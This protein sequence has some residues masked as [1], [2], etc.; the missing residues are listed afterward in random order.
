MLLS[1]LPAEAVIDILVTMVT[2][3][4]ASPQGAPFMDRLAGI[5]NE[6]LDLYHGRQPSRFEKESLGPAR[7]FS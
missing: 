3:L 6:T 2:V 1:T 5:V 4:A 7:A